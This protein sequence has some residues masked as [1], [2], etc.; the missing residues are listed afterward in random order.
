M[1]IEKTNTRTH[2]HRS[3]MLLNSVVKPQR[4]YV[5][6]PITFYKLH[7]KIN[8]KQLHIEALKIDNGCNG[9]NRTEIKRRMSNE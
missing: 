7:S 1:E 2:I 6:V 8:N 4:K 9:S 5:L 3:Q